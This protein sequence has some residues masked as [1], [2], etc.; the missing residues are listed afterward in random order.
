MFGP[1]RG[2]WDLTWR[3][4]WGEEPPYHVPTFVLTHHSRPSLAMQGDTTFHFV[5]DGIDAALVRIRG[6]GAKTKIETLA[7]MM[8][9]FSPRDRAAIQALATADAPD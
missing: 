7:A 3:G 4:W 9:R 1:I 6:S 5:T 2:E 8:R